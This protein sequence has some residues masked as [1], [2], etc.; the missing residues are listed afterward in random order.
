MPLDLFA[1]PCIRNGSTYLERRSV[2]SRERERRLALIGNQVRRHR[3]GHM[4]RHVGIKAPAAL[5]ILHIST[6]AKLLC[7]VI[8]TILPLVKVRAAEAAPRFDVLCFG[9][10]TLHAGRHLA[11]VH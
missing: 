3:V 5:P 4:Y 9:L 1:S 2:A 7:K 6:V 11:T 8:D 10:P